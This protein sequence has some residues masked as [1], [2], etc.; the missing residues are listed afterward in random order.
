MIYYKLINL[1]HIFIVA[2]ILWLIGTGK[3]EEYKHYLTWVAVLIVLY[4]GYRLFTSNKTECMDSVSGSPIHYI[5]MFDSSPGY[6]KP[7]LHINLG[8]VVVWTNIG[9]I[10]HTVTGLN[11]EFNSGIMKPGDSFSVKFDHEG[12]FEYMCLVERGWM[13][14]LIIVK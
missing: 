6:S 13:K 9:E 14:G 5:K 1:F 7:K 4:H 3:L 10:E 11:N 8:D 12:A 2:P